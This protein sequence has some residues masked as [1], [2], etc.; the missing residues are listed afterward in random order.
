MKQ[1]IFIVSV[2]LMFVVGCGQDREMLSDTKF[3]V[4]LRQKISSI[5]ENAEAQV[6]SITGNCTSVIDAPMRQELIDAGANV[7]T[8][9]GETFT[10]EVSSEDVFNVAALEFVTQLKLSGGKK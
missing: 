1:V 7:Q 6:L 9:N 3:D 10:A 4:S 8:M 5:G 2:M